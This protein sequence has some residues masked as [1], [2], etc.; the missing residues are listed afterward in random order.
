M[1]KNAIV[2]KPGK[3]LINGITSAN[4]GKPDY[5]KAAAQHAGYVAALKKC[6]VAVTVL[7]ADEGFPDSVFVEDT[8]VVTARCAVITN[9]GAA[10]RKG[11]EVAVKEA[12]SGFHKNIECIRPPGTLDGGDVMMVGN[13]FYTGLSARTNREG[14]SQL[15]HILENY[16]YSGSTVPLK[17]VLHLKT[18][19][20]YLENNTLMAAGEFIDLPVFETFDKI[21][22]DRSESYA[23]NCIWVNGTVIMPAGFEKTKSAVENAGYGVL[24]VDVSEFRKLDGGVSCMS[25]RF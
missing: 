21:C 20:A 14:A 13:H 15:I 25:L 1:F 3:S 11:E 24:T 7:E 12:L 6:G 2:R 8:A 9:P 10:S 16:G 19:L 17:K 18:G 4:L 22:I 5:D 23:A